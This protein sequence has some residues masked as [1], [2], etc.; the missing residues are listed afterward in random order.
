MFAGLCFNDEVEKD[1]EF[2][3]TVDVGYLLVDEV[4]VFAGSH[5]LK[6]LS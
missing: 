1:Q 3:E 6:I 2:V 4:G 5:C